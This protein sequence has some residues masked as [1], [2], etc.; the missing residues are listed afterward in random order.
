MRKPRASRR[1]KPE[2]APAPVIEGSD[3]VDITKGGPR[4]SETK[5]AP[6]APVKVDP[7]LDEIYK[8]E[9][10]DA[11]LEHKK[12]VGP[13]DKFEEMGEH[14]FDVMKQVGVKKTSEVLDIGC[15]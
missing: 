6:K 5:V 2:D 9:K 7:F 4:A 1:K 3:A 8:Q 12:F 13:Q 10:I 11:A 14:Q 15:S